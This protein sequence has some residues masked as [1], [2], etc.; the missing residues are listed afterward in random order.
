MISNGIFYSKLIY[1]INV[2][3][4]VWRIPGILDD[5]RRSSPT[6]T[7]EDHRKLQV[8]Q[9]VILRLKTGMG[10]A[11]HVK[12]LL[13]EAKQLSVQQLAAYHSVLSIFKC[14]S[15]RQPGY[16]HNRL[17]PEI[18]KN[19]KLRN[20]T[21]QDIQIGFELTLARS[22]FF[23]RASRIWNALEL[24]AKTS[25]LV[26]KLKKKAKTWIKNHISECPY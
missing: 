14:I 18:N 22:S 16:M 13:S 23:Y 2:W 7:L 15:A 8:L 5:K 9:N 24:D 25:T 17:F 11:T 4:G 3:G 21:N 12:T 26:N 1:C 19:L 6:I 10:K 20:T